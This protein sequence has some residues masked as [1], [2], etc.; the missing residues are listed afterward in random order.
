[1]DP[2][3]NRVIGAV[4]AR[5]CVLFNVD[6]FAF[7][8]AANHFHALVRTRSDGGA[9]SAFVAYVEANIARR[10]GHLVGWHGR[11]WH[12]RFSAEP[13]LDDEA[14]I[15][16]IR[17][18]LAHG[19]KEGLV[20]R[21]HEW[22]GLT[23]LPELAHGVVRYFDHLDVAGF[24][25]AARVAEKSGKQV[26]RA[27]AHDAEAQAK[28]ERGDKPV[29]GVA[30]ILAQD[31]LSVPLYTKRSP[32]PLCHA[33]TRE[34]W[35]GFRDGYRAFLDAYRTASQLFRQGVASVPFPPHCFRPPLPWGWVAAD[36]G[37]SVRALAAT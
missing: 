27:L 10:V 37:L 12:R 30:A 8:F 22:P 28:A 4:L 18:I 13:V 2:A 33:S 5:A 17:Y 3:V 23:C 21:A 29:L 25:E 16:R 1:P 15:D 35:L 36:D 6:L 14:L 9:L 19:V 31:P 26:A 7:T 24:N 20:E 11:F 34:A 32:R